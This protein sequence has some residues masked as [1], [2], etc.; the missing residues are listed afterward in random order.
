MT[1]TINS[2]YTKPFLQSLFL[3]GG[4]KYPV[5]PGWI[6]RSMYIISHL[7]PEKWSLPSL[8]E[9]ILSTEGVTV[10]GKFYDKEQLRLFVR[11][12]TALDRSAILKNQSKFPR[13]NSAVPLVL[14]A[15]KVNHG[16]SYERWGITKEDESLL[17]KSFSGYFDAREAWK[18]LQNEV[19][20]ADLRAEVSA[21][22]YANIKWY[23]PIRPMIERKFFHMMLAQTWI[24]EP[25]IRS[26]DMVTTL[27]S[28]SAVAAPIEKP[29]KD[30]E[31]YS[32]VQV[33]LKDESNLLPW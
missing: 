25:D 29:W 15:Y 26:E 23:K 14:A 24:F 2:Y 32:Q 17:G 10:D 20:L 22:K 4:P 3:D 7:V 8:K 18:E 6:D 30:S 12:F 11:A 9:A 5:P 28:L 21:P 19:D 13:H 33:E 1:T 16:V 31:D 27:E